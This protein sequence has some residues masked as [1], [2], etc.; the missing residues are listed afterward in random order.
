MSPDNN[1]YWASKSGLDLA[2][3]AADKVDRFY[4]NLLT[5]VMYRRWQRAYRTFHGLPGGGDPFDISRVGQTGKEGELV[6]I[7]LNHAGSLAQHTVSLVSQTVPEFEA[8]SH[9]FRL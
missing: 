1:V 5:S 4:D 7:K 2:E 9:Q 8:G 3:A 6:S